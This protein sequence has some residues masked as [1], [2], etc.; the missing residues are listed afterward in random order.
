MRRPPAWIAYLAVGAL[1]T[2]AYVLRAAVPGSG[3]VMNL[4][5]LSPVLAIIVG[6]RLHRPR[7]VAPWA[8]FAVGFLLFWFGDLY[9]YSY[10]LLLDRD[11]PFPSLGD[12][13]YVLVYPVL[14]AGLLLLIR[15]R[16]SRG[17][18]GGVIDGLILT[19]GLVAA[20]VDRADGAV[21]AR[22]RALDGG[23]ARLD[24]ISARRRPAAGGGDPARRSTAA[25]ARPRSTCSARASSC[26]SRPTSCTAC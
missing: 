6:V 18:R 3:P 2:A 16:S 20:A 19:V 22:Q 10:P 15:R 26:C 17:D 13:A 12:A 4:L 8:L 24:R 21:R 1:L 5:G 7:S 9:T 23:Q 14:M 11:V 25:G